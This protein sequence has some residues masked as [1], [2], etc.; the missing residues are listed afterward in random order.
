V[1]I[2]QGKLGLLFITSVPCL[3]NSLNAVLSLGG[4]VCWARTGGQIV[5]LQYVLRWLT[6]EVNVHSQLCFTES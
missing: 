1:F 2:L 6:A 4:T 3:E 5:Q